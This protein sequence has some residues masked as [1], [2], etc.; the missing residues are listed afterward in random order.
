MGVGTWTPQQLNQIGISRVFLPPGSSYDSR[1]KEPQ[2]IDSGNLSIL[3][4]NLASA[5]AAVQ[6]DIPGSDPLSNLFQEDFSDAPCSA[7]LIQET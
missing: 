5:P 2:F 6:I 7:S 4:R 1:W 3:W